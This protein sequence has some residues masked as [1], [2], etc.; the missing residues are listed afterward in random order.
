[1][2]GLRDCLLSLYVPT[3]FP[4]LFVSSSVMFSHF[5]PCVPRVPCVPCVPCVLWVPVCVQ[6]ASSV[7]TQFSFWY[8]LHIFI[9]W[10]CPCLL[11]VYAAYL[12][13]FLL[14]WTWISALCVKKKEGCFLFCC[15]P[16]SVPCFW[17]PF[18]GFDLSDGW[19]AGHQVP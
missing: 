16:A 10:I 17:V 15:L 7:C 9:S 5:S 2:F 11:L 8:F 13:C 14:V 12:F 4:S 6:S 1:M 3:V 18:C 19:S